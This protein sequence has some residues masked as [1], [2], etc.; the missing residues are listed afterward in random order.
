MAEKNQDKNLNTLRT[1]R[2]FKRQTKDI[3][4]HF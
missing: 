4:H 3:F 1:E 2:A